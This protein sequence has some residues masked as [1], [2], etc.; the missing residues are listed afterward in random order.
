[1][2]GGHDVSASQET[3]R[4]LGNSAAQ[5]TRYA[6]A[7]LVP[8]AVRGIAVGIVVW[9]ATVGAV[10]GP[11][12][13]SLVAPGHGAPTLGD[14]LAG[15][16]VVLALM[17]GA[18]AVILVFLRHEP[19]SRHE[20]EAPGGPA[21]GSPTAAPVGD[22]NGLGI[23]ELARAPAVRIG[24]I[25]L[26]AAGFAM[27]AIMTMTPIHL[28]EHGHGLATV[29]LVL[30][31]H[32]LGMFAF[33]PLSGRLADRQGPRPIILVGFMVMVVAAILAASAPMEGGPLLFSA[34]FLL[35]L[36]W[37]L[38]FVSGSVLLAREVPPRARIR[39]QGF[40]DTL[41]WG[42]AAIASTGAGFVLE[43]ADYPL[44]ALVGAVLALL[45]IAYILVTSGSRVAAEA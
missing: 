1:M 23:A 22:P 11:N 6:A 28:V 30:S 5:L 17:L 15:F 12:L 41:V 32:T 24:L 45:P 3:R 31:A 27:V 18:L 44:L 10:V 33:A 29:G 36:G 40:T 26:V 42:S 8:P 21:S 20:E 14:L 9:A 25:T 2:F 43:L 35:G 4:A 19:P 37:N 13:P 34:L 38:A 16:V 7:D 39:L